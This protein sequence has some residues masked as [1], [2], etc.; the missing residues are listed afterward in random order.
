MAGRYHDRPVMDPSRSGAGA[1]FA[2][3]SGRMIADA[4][5]CQVDDKSPALPGPVKLA[6]T[7]SAEIWPSKR[8][9][10]RRPR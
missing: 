10:S 4:S 6:M 5:V 3:A 9:P 2:L 7:Q 1:T 8:Y